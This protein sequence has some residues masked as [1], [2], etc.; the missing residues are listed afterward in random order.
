MSFLSNDLI[1][2]VMFRILN[3][4]SSQQ[5]DSIVPEDV[6]RVIIKNSRKIL[7]KESC[8]LNLKGNF[9]IVGDLHGD[10]Q[11]LIR[12]F[13]KN[14]YPPKTSYLFLGDYTDRG[15]K[16][17]EV[18]LLLFSLKVLFPDSIYL[19]RGNHEFDFMNSLYGFKDECL[20]KFNEDIYNLFENAFQ[21]LPISAI[22]NKYIF[23]VHGG[24]S[25][26]IYSIKD[27]LDLE[28]PMDNKDND[29]VTDLLW[30]DPFYYT[31]M[32]DESPRK[33][34]KVFGS[35]ALS[36]FFKN[37]GLKLVIRSHEC[38]SKGYEYPL[39]MENKII[40]VFSSCDY[41]GSENDAAFIKLVKG[42]IKISTLSVLTNDS[43][44]KFRPIYPEQLLRLDKIPISVY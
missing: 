1:Y 33:S 24:I 38:V 15:T 37:T 34:G 18:V 7:K 43:I 36:T 23:C 12:I 4:S 44:K 2:D 21:Q 9:V 20:K 40:T 22:I 39:G 11:T 10:L 16:S 32:Y 29:I 30:S 8:V 17:C 3:S 27:L 28:K 42:D 25:Q 14:G 31:S 35:E 19:L 13:G 26:K 5:D 6:A 41:C